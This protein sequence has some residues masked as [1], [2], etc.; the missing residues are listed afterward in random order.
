MCTITLSYDSNNE[1][2]QQQLT[3][4][5]STG[6]FMQIDDEEGLDI[7]YTDPSLFEDD[8][9]PLPS[10][11]NLSIDELELLVVDDIRNICEMKDAV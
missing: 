6:L 11:R 1:L 3:A 5:L 10:D 7:D 4:L 9:I 2:A 8:V